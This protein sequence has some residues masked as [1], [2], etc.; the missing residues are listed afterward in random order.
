MR[1]LLQFIST[2][3]FPFHFITYM[4]GLSILNRR[5]HI[6]VGVDPILVGIDPNDGL[7]LFPQKILNVR[8]YVLGLAMFFY[9]TLGSNGQVV[10]YNVPLA[11]LVNCAEPGFCPGPDV[12]NN[13]IGDIGFT[14]ISG[15]PAPAISVSVSFNYDIECGGGGNSYG[16][17][18]NT[19]AQPGTFTPPD[20]CGVCQPNNIYT[21]ICNPA[22][23]NSGALNTFMIESSAIGICV[24]LD[25][26]A[27]LGGFY[28]QITVCY[29]SPPSYSTCPANQTVNTDPGLCTAVVPYVTV[30]DGCPSST[31]SYTFAGATV[32][33]G[34]GNGS[35][36]AFNVGVT[37]VTVTAT[38]GN[39]PDA[40]CV[41]TVT[42]NDLQ[43]PT[44]ICPADV[45]IS[46]DV[47]L[48]SSS[49]VVLGAPLIGDNCGVSSVV[50][51]GVSPYPVGT[52]VV[53]WTVTDING[54][55]NTCTQNVTVTDNENPTITCP[56]DQTVNNDPGL[57]SAIVNGIA[58]MASGDNC[59]GTAITYNIVGATVGAG[60][61]DVSGTAFNVGLSTVTYIITDASSNTASCSFNVTVNDIEVPTIDRKSVV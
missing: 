55:T 47:G 23:Y 59:P 30:V 25:V 40:T 54:N 1:K 58:P 42:V 56:A 21:F 33:A 11:D 36:S 48:C 38:N 61:N 35:G 44:A 49:A 2:N 53:T 3:F 29:Q 18:L 34:A 52:T 39:P 27:A 50:D 13:C 57:C 16:T 37:T 12:Y 28:A 51:D 45:T 7:P 43:L 60:V 14:W 24:G 22:D 31:E 5:T 15:N 20:D 4:I 41:F 10:V 9:C 17:T 26:D 46:A 8:K 6:P 19:L 32:G